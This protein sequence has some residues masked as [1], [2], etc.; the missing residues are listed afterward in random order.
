MA[1]SQKR[2]PGWSRVYTRVWWKA[3]SASVTI[4][5]LAG[6]R[7]RRGGRRAVVIRTADVVI[8]GGGVTGVSIAFSLAARGVLPTSWCSA[9]LSSLGGTGRSVG[10]VRQLYPPPETTQMVVRSLRVFQQFREVTGGDAS[11]VACGCL[12]GVAPRCG[13]TLQ[14]TVARQRARSA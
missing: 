6:A 8:V 7:G 11:C 4:R 10:I 13:E 1:V 12:I 14:A 9:A 2:N 3:R 5:V